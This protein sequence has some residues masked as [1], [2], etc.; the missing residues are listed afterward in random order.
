[1]AGSKE[2]THL[3]TDTNGLCRVSNPPGQK[4][5]ITAW[6]SGRSAPSSASIGT[7]AEP[8]R[9]IVPIR[10]PIRGRVVDPAGRP[11][12]G[13]QIGRLVAMDDWAEDPAARRRFI[14]FPFSRTAAHPMT[15]LDG[16]F[17]LDLPVKTDTRG[18]TKGGE[19]RL[20]PQ[21]LCFADAACRRVAFVALDRRKPRAAYD[22]TLAPTRQVRFP[23][24]HT[25]TSAS[26]GSRPGGS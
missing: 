21:A 17:L 20:F 13:L 7:T 18:I 25:V 8:P 22:V 4:C 23:V 24:E 9:V 2:W 19:L 1:M 3:R 5:K 16:R 15:D 14:L 26:G 12:A 6:R 10:E 11:V